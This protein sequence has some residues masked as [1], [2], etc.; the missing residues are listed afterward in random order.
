M[1]ADFVAHMEAALDPVSSTGQALYAEPYDSQRPVVCFD[2]S[3]TQLL[4]ESRDPMPVK[5]SRPKRQGHEYRREGTRNLFLTCEPKAGWRDVAITE[6]R[7]K[8]G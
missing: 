3:S 6:R 2:E 1:N 5:P 7:T 4:A 8:E